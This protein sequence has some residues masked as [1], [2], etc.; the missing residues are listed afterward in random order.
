M[1]KKDILFGNVYIL[2]NRGYVN[3]VYVDNDL[4]V[5]V[6]HVGAKYIHV[7]LE[8]RKGG[9]FKVLPRELTEMIW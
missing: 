1:R 2:R 8:E 4:L 3:G 5:R 7:M 9:S 6:T